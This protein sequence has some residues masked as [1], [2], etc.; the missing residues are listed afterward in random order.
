MAVSGRPFRGG[1]P[2]AFFRKVMNDMAVNQT[3]QLAVE[4]QGPGKVI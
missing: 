3:S 2:S 1:M 4:P